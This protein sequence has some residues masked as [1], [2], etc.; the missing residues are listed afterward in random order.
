MAR[1]QPDYSVNH[2]PRTVAQVPCVAQAG[3]ALT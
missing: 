1:P 2:D 3:D